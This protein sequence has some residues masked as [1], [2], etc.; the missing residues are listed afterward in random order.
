[1]AA[2]RNDQNATNKKSSRKTK[3][4]KRKRLRRIPPTTPQGG[5][6]P[7]WGLGW[8][9]DHL[10][11]LNRHGFPGIVF[12]LTGGALLWVA[13]YLVRAGGDLTVAGLVGVIAIAVCLTALASIVITHTTPRAADSDE[14]RRRA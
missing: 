13:T 7:S 10:R 5:D 6:D 3:P 14:K 4:R 12:G 2:R 9:R 1:M 8:F 11:V